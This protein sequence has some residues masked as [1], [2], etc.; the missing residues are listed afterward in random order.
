[1]DNNNIQ[2]RFLDLYNTLLHTTLVNYNETVD[3]IRQIEYGIREVLRQNSSNQQIPSPIVRP[4]SSLFNS[5][6][7]GNSNGTGNA[8]GTGTGNMN[9][10]TSLSDRYRNIANTLNNSNGR[11]NRQPQNGIY[12]SGQLSSS[13]NNHQPRTERPM[14]IFRP[15][16]NMPNR[17]NTIN[18]EQL[19]NLLSTMLLYSFQPT[20]VD[21]LTPVVVR[22]TQSEINNATEVIP[23]DVDL[24]NDMC[25]ITQESFTV[26][27][28][29]IRI[30]HCGHCFKT[31]A[32][33][34]WFSTSVFCPVCRYDIRQYNTSST[35]DVSRE[36][37]D[38]NE[39]EDDD[40][41]HSDATDDEQ[42]EEHHDDHSEDMVNDDTT[43]HATESR[44][45]QDNTTT[46]TANDNNSTNN[47]AR[48]NGETNFNALAM[49]F[50]NSFTSQ[51]ANSNIT[52]TTNSSTTTTTT[53]GTNSGTTTGTNPS[54]V[55]NSQIL[56]NTDISNNI[57]NMGDIVLEYTIQTHPNSLPLTTST[58][59]S[60][61]NI[62]RNV[63]N[64]NFTR[65]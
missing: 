51:L 27:D 54:L 38:Q 24:G 35:N 59:D 3:T 32:I 45:S 25:P 42:G 50:F 8:Y 46:T 19:P 9:T 57:F 6:L 44:N 62:L 26:N 55:S 10:N 18:E 30:H 49:D 56:N 40:D 60:L 2:S 47:T 61:Q 43:N 15:L 63:I 11:Q 21:N 37:G 52:S 7:N 1:M 48:S 4:N 13:I 5:N 20:N 22:P 58:T 31:D 12:P 64:S 33:N 28:H 65:R 36:N 17:V 29:V 23:W 14:P 41:D 16:V 34:R 53:T 39:D